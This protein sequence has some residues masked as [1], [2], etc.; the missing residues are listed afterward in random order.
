MVDKINGKPAE[1]AWFERDVSFVSI[2]SS[3]ADFE[4]P[5]D[6][7]VDGPVEMV[8]RVLQ[9]RGTL[10]GISRESDNVLHVIFGYS[11]GTFLVDPKGTDV[12]AQL[13][14]ELNAIPTLGTFTL[15]L[16]TKFITA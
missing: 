2:T 8:V 9:T 12:L 4:S 15:A 1:S 10:L 7:G 5:A 3:A 13:T 16:G 14:A 6:F 11:A